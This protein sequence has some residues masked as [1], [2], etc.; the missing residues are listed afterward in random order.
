[1]TN[2][3]PK[4][5]KT[6]KFQ[7]KL[8]LVFMF[9]WVLVA[10][11]TVASQQKTFKAALATDYLTNGAL[12]EPEKVAGE[13]SKIFD[14]WN[15]LVSLES[16]GFIIFV[17]FVVTVFVII[18]IAK[19]RDGD[20]EQS[21]NST[22]LVVCVVLFILALIL[23]VGVIS[24]G[25]TRYVEKVQ[26]SPDMSQRVMQQRMCWINLP[27]RTIGGGFQFEIDNACK[28]KEIVENQM[29]DKFM[30]DVSMLQNKVKNGIATPLEKSYLDGVEQGMKAAQNDSKRVLNH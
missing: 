21:L 18:G 7:I 26:I 6:H 2:L 3:I 5:F 15:P 17:A 13:Q 19:V 27:H 28:R 24:S 29:I 20:Y 25:K 10:M 14:Y 1:M 30:S 4:E 8:L 11:F 12:V 9:L 22:A 16:H 23:Y